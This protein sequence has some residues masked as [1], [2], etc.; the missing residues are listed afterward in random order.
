[1]R[2]YCRQ[3]S[4]KVPAAVFFRR[5]Q[6]IGV[7]GNADKDAYV[8]A[9]CFGKARLQTLS[10]VSRVLDGRP[11]RLYPWTP[12]I[13]IGST[14]SFS[15]EYSLVVTTSVVITPLRR[16]GQSQSSASPPS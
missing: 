5:P 1:M 13:A 15:S 2:S 14:A 11:N 9:S 4:F 6:M 3:N 12:M 10:T 16:G 7:G 8:H